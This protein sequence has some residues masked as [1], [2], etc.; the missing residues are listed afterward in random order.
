MHFISD[1]LRNYV[2]NPIL[3]EPELLAKLNKETHQKSCNLAC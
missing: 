3:T 1:D 2:T